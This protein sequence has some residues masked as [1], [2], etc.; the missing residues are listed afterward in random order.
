MFKDFQ[1]KNFQ[2]HKKN[3]LEFHPQV[4]VIVGKSQSGKTA[5]LRALNL[6]ITNRPLGARYFPDFAG[7]KGA[8]DLKLV[9]QEGQEISLTKDISLSKDGKKTVRSSAYS[10]N[11]DPEPYEAFGDKVPDQIQT[12]LNLSELN[13]QRQFD[14]PF[15]ICS[16]PGEVARV[17]NR[18]TQLEKVDGWV[19][20]LTTMVN[21]ERSGVKIIESQ[22]VKTEEELEKYK[23]VLQAE[24]NIQKAEKLQDSLNSVSSRAADI[25]EIINTIEPKAEDIRGV[26]DWLQVEGLVEE[27]NKLS[28][29]R[30]EK[31]ELG[32]GLSNLMEDILGVQS[33]KEYYEEIFTAEPL[34]GELSDLF[35]QREAKR[36]K[37]EQVGQILGRLERMDIGAFQQRKNK[38]VS[39]YVSIIKELGRCPTCFSPIDEKRIKEIVKEI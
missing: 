29:Q 14:E 22:L 30:R 28:S 31:K 24:R 1:I 4:N 15:L 39:E 6:L 3:R 13:M 38:L 25:E 5:I 12:L 9:L 36:D 37:A 32:F 27:A 26:K 18:V 34:V 33:N 16:S 11:N 20:E 2:S 10:L 8:A 23:D 19:S 21:T 7:S 35:E 17:L